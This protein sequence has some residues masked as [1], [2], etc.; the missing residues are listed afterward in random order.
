MAEVPK[1]GVRPPSPLTLWLFG[2]L[3]LWALYTAVFIRSAGLPVGEASLRAFANVLPL[4][5][6]SAGTRAVLKIYVMRWSTLAQALSH[7]A[8]AVVF[9]LAWYAALLFLLAL[10]DMLKGTT[11]RFPAFRL[12]LRRGRLFKA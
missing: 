11:S 2:S 4:A 9:S 1:E 10:I 3:G 7:V 12:L 5:L 6:I 8:L